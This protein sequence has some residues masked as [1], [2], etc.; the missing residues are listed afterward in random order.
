MIL[1]QAEGVCL[2]VLDRSNDAIN[3][4]T[5]LYNRIAYTEIVKGCVTTAITD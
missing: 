2:W 5:F 1:Q 4:S 3:M